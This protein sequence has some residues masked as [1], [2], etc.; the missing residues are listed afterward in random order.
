MGFTVERAE[1]KTNTHTHTHAHTHTHLGGH[2]DDE[3]ETETRRNSTGILLG[4]NRRTNKKRGR[5]KCAKKM[6]GRK[7]SPK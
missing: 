7:S 5:E 3:K 6:E 2:Q 4:Q 1:V